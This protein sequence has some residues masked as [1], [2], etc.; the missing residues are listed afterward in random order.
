M[1]CFTNHTDEELWKE[2]QNDDGK[3]FDEI[4][5]RY[6]KK[7][8]LFVLNKTRSK[9]A[10]ADIVQDLFASL[11]ERR[12]DV[13]IQNLSFYLHTAAKYK[14]IN[15]I[16]SEISSRRHWDYYR[17]FLP[18]SEESTA[19]AVEFN[20]LMEALENSIEQLPDKS[21]EIFKQSRFE[22][23]SVEE[24]SRHY[25]LTGKAVEY[26]I[27]QSLRYLRLHLKDFR[28]FTLFHILYCLQF[29]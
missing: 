6:W 10:T 1:P 26:H 29:L 16:K 23:K 5:N 11:W 25:N 7:M 8:H 3:A 18:T 17:Q 22:G 28:L 21:K 2:V 4:F 9:E 12:H 19:K 20:D 24:L 27:T 14:C 13:F 15:F